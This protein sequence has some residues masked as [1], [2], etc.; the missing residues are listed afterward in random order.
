MK[1]IFSKATSA[2]V[3]N[4]SATFDYELLV[5]AIFEFDRLTKVEML[6][7]LVK[8]SHIVEEYSKFVITVFGEIIAYVVR[9]FKIF[10][11]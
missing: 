9:L 11:Y 8:L 6:L 10:H 3:D 2:N 1:I 4:N 5:I 7:Y